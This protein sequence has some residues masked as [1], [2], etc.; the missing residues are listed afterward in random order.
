MQGCDKDGAQN[1]EIPLTLA[2]HNINNVS[3]VLTLHILLHMLV[4]TLSAYPLSL[5]ESFTYNYLNISVPP[6]QVYSKSNTWVKILWSKNKKSPPSVLEKL[7]LTTDWRTIKYIKQE[8]KAVWLRGA[9]WA[10]NCIG[11]LNFWSIFWWMAQ[12]TKFWSRN[13]FCSML[14]VVLDIKG[15]STPAVL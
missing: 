4:N 11:L 12:N 9:G 5:L 14:S 6:S 10:A 1:I 8:L 15:S 3:T 13:V 2:H 7:L